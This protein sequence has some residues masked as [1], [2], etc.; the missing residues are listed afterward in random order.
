M[1]K[2]SKTVKK[3]LDEMYQEYMSKKAIKTQKAREK[4]EESSS[5]SWSEGTKTSDNLGRTL[6]CSWLVSWSSELISEAILTQVIPIKR[7]GTATTL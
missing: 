1:Q 6:L 7:G 2:S 3:S 4:E 5:W